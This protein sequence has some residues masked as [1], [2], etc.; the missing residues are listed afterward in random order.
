VG[1]VDLATGLYEPWVQLEGRS[2]QNVV[3]DWS[4]DRRIVLTN[5]T[6]VDG[7]RIFEMAP[8]ERGGAFRTVL[9]QSPAFEYV[10]VV[11]PTIDGW[12]IA[13]DRG[14]GADAPGI[15]IWHV[16]ETGTQLVGDIEGFAPELAMMRHYHGKP[17]LEDGHIGYALEC[18]PQGDRC[19]SSRV[20]FAALTV[21]PVGEVRV[22]GA[23]ALGGVYQRPLA[24]GALDA[25]VEEPVFSGGSTEPTGK[26][27]WLVR[28]PGDAAP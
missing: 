18:D 2:A 17:R 28:V 8:L 3:W 1:F 13:S 21:A 10:G 20:D 7:A 16:T 14:D 25:Q 5:G 9:E 6:F 12:Y 4:G 23:T 19:H 22:E 27:Y 24:C 15:R 11:M 26:R